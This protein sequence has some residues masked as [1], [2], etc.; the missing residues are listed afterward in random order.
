VSQ[1]IAKNLKYFFVTGLMAQ[2]H[3]LFLDGKNVV[4]IHWGL[5]SVI[6]M[7]FDYVSK[8]MKY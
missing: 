4:K 8:S 7:Y 5:N 2:K 6:V 3:L 1:L